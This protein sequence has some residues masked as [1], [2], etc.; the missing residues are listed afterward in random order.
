MKNESKS[1]I[2]QRDLN[3][4]ICKHIQ[5][6]SNGTKIFEKEKHSFYIITSIL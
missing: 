3:M 4:N 5:Y 1:R 6:V 2:I